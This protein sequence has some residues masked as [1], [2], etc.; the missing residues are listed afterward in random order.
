MPPLLYD[1][2]DE[3]ADPRKNNKNNNVS[4]LENYDNNEVYVHLKLDK[5]KQLVNK[6][7]SSKKKALNN[8]NDE[9]ED[10]DDNDDDN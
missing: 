7:A 1:D 3:S 10:N 9:N 4:L 8:K 2:S 5:I 6:R